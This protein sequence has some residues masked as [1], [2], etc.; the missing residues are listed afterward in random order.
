[1]IGAYALPVLSY[2]TG[3]A[4]HAQ[5]PTLWPLLLPLLVTSLMLGH[6]YR[7]LKPVLLC[8]SLGLIGIVWAS[9]RSPAPSQQDPA[10]FAPAER[11]TLTGTLASDITPK[12]GQRWMLD[13]DTQSL[14][15]QGSSQTLS[16]KL[17]VHL[18]TEQLPALRIGDTVS[19]SGR[20]ARPQPALNFGAFSYR[21]YLRHQGIF[22]VVYA[23]DIN[24]IQN[25][26]AWAPFRLLQGLRMQILSGFERGLP[27]EQ[28]RLLGSLLLGAGASPVPEK[29]QQNFQATGLQH[30]LAVSG[31]QV[32][33][34]VLGVL[35]LC[36]LLRLPRL[37]SVL[38]CLGCLWTFVAL[39]GFPASV[40]RAGMVASL[41]L[42]GYLR[43]RSLDPVA[44]L[45]LGCGGLMLLD[46]HL[47]FDIGFQF[48]ALAT[49]GLILLSPVL[50]K[51]ADWLPLPVSG[52]LTPILAA[53]L[54]VLPAQLYHFGSFSWLFL[55]AN[56]LA[57][58]LTTALSWLAIIAAFLCWLP[59]LQA[60]VL[61]PA[62][63]LCAGFLSGVEALLALPSPV[64]TGPTL[65]LSLLLLT[66]ALLL[67]LC[68]PDSHL[69]RVLP[70]LLLTVPLLSGGLWL[71]ERVSCP[72]R[73]TFLSVGQGDATLIET[74]DQVILVDAGP[75]WETDEGFS[76]AGEKEILPYLHKRGIR[77]I[78]LA[79]LS[80]AHLDHFG[81]FVSLLDKIEIK[82][83]K[84]VPGAGE[85][86]AYPELLKRIQA[87][88]IPFEHAGNGS[89]EQLAPDLKLVYWQPMH[90]EQ[91]SLNDQSLVVQLIHGN[92]RML[93]SGDLEAEGEAAL[94]R[95]P[96]FIPEH[97]ILKVPHHGSKT[98]S[99]PEFLSQ[100]SP[101]DAI[102]S[103]GERNR[104][105]HP[106]PEVVSRYAE[107]GIRAWRTDNT[108]AVCV[109]SRGSDYT[110][111]TAAR[112]AM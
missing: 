6:R 29:I 18:K 89:I 110:V 4:L 53:Q 79:I 62:G 32:Q 3:I 14:K 36:L 65:A 88:N 38:I 102:M 87:K 86:S 112:I 16:G 94:L 97:A 83:F 76:D 74:P 54:F 39:T 49:F 45:L 109:C 85:G 42:L 12:G 23:R 22:A 34:L 30:V 9:L 7:R 56:L 103:V 66:Y 73:V 63:W 8:I 27:I 1:M 41:G 58:L 77:H 111:R 71:G 46:P 37:A 108:G 24:K 61:I 20:L 105:K 11:V 5:I 106:S 101:T 13:L 50:I 90:D 33:L 99:T 21:D 95:E 82:Q 84:T 80:H 93:L 40:L 75:R 67:G 44:G 59:P 25:G 51:K 55:P 68:R 72:V 81:G 60:L 15:V 31:F 57:G 100:I 91:A 64:L 2:A 78:D 98:S 96:G 107:A 48:S 104:Y 92:V 47:L 70:A 52:A 10:H 17:R 19:V 28:A 35:G 43:F 69:R 26:P